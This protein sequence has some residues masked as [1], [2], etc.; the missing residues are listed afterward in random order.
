[1][2][3]TISRVAWGEADTVVYTA[4]AYKMDSVALPGSAHITRL[5]LAK[6]E[7]NHKV[8]RTI[9]SQIFTP[10]FLDTT[11]APL[12]SAQAYTH[13]DVPIVVAPVKE[14]SKNALAAAAAQ[15]LADHFGLQIAKNITE[16]D[17]APRKKMKPSDKLLNLP[18]FRGPI[19]EGRSYII[20]DDMINSGGTIAQLRSYILQ[21]GG[22]MAFACTLATRTGNHH[23]L[24]NDLYRINMV[25]QALGP[26]L[27][28]QLESLTGLSLNTLTRKETCLLLERKVQEDIL[29]LRYT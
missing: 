24:S 25:E 26:A 29:A 1:M 8:A 20:V 23:L 3:K 27:C 15:K 21:N 19:E 2:R 18:V 13:T 10:F 28:D 12:L 17:C 22:K 11:I 16:T 14:N 6:Y 7:A 4:S 9:A 5:G